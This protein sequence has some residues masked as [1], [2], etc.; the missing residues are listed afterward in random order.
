[1]AKRVINVG[2]IICFF[3]KRIINLLCYIFDSAVCLHLFFQKM[4]SW[5]SHG[6][7]F[8]EAEEDEATAT[9]VAEEIK[10]AEIELQQLQLELAAEKIKVDCDLK[11]EDASAKAAE[12]FNPNQRKQR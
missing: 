12:E 7:S 1:M 9:E 11:A 8:N 2:C 5:M 6:G 10:A 4:T 3:F